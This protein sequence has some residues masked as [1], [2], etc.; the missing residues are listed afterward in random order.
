MFNIEKELDEIRSIDVSPSKKLI[1]TTTRMVESKIA[2]HKAAK[3]KT[4][5]NNIIKLSSFAALPAAASLLLA[6]VIGLVSPQ[7]AAYYTVDINQNIVMSVDENGY[8][9]DIDEELDTLDVDSLKGETVEYAVSQTIANADLEDNQD[10]LIGCFG[11]DEYNNI[12]KNQIS[13]YLGN[14][15]LNINMLSVHGTMNDWQNADKLNV[16]A[17][18][19]LLGSF[20]Q[21]DIDDTVN[22]STLI[23]M[24]ESGEQDI[25]QLAE[26]NA[27][28]IKYTAPNLKY[29]IKDN[30]INIHWDYIDYKSINY[31]GNITYRLLSSDTASGIVSNSEILDTYTF[32][33]WEKQPTDYTLAYNNEH[34][35]KYYAIAAVYD[36][37]TVVLLD[38]YIYVQ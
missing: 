38:E 36:A 10:V 15:A 21:I 33:S 7:A 25:Y 1:D 17:G 30:Y 18:L 14:T 13:N 26:Q 28:P 2:E 20:A 5:R 16:S 19:Y 22:L 23:N 6:I 27:E 8:V 11:A 37:N 31:D 3:A 34:T 9:I 32:A 12:S 24:I 35:N 29:Y 4:R